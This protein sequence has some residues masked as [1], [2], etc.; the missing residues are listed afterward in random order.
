MEHMLNDP[1]TWVATAFVLFMIGFVKLALPKI[2]AMLDNRS[3]QIRDELDRAVALREEAEAV[4]AEYQQKQRE[5]LAQ[6][7]Q[8][9]QQASDDADR[10]KAA[11]EEEMK[12]IVKRRSKS[13]QEKIERAQQDA[14]RLVQANMVDIATQA[15]RTLIIEHL[16][17]H[18]DDELID[19]ALEQVERI[20]H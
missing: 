3:Q 17:T 15:A 16:E 1:V 19:Y 2:A 14:L 12:E 6:A 4:L 10:M 11:A 18:G 20:V 7:E 9:L 13:A 8:I 5:M